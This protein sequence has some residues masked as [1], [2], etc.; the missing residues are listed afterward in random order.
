MT[1]VIF[2]FLYPS[3]LSSHNDFLSMFILDGMFRSYVSTMSSFSMIGLGLCFH[4]FSE[5]GILKFFAG[6]PVDYSAYIAV[7][8]YVQVLGQFSNISVLTFVV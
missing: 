8:L 1:N 2:N 4:D 6:V 7:P 5:T 3:T